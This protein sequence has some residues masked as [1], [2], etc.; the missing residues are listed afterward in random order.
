MYVR[1]FQFTETVQSC[2][3]MSFQ[4]FFLKMTETMTLS[5]VLTGTRTLCAVKISILWTGQIKTISHI[6]FSYILNFNLFYKI[7]RRNGNTRLQFESMAAVSG[8]VV[9]ILSLHESSTSSIR[10]LNSSFDFRKTFLTCLPK[11]FLLEEGGPMASRV[12]IKKKTKMR[13]KIRIR[14]KVKVQIK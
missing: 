12:R 8:R 4:Q 11:P 9:Q 14:I 10:F 7:F 6:F 5:K 2:L 13:I 1:F 3:L